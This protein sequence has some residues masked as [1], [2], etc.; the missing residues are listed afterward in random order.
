[1]QAKDTRPP[2]RRAVRS[3]SPAL[4]ALPALDTPDPLKYPLTGRYQADGTPLRP[5]AVYLRE[6]ERDQ[7]K[8]SFETQYERARRAATLRLLLGDGP[9]GL[10]ERRQGQPHGLR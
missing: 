2:R 5:A 1:M 8:W 7:G 3:V 9:C 10:Q 4:V 6:S